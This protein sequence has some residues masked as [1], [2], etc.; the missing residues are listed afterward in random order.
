M[1]SYEALEPVF[2]YFVIP[3]AYKLLLIEMRVKRLES[4]MLQSQQQP[5]KEAA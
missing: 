2:K 5:K 1:I 4:V 3:L